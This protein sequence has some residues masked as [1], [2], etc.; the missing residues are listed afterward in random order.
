[1]RAALSS[2]RRPGLATARI[3]SRALDAF[4][5]DVPTL[6]TTLARLQPLEPGDLVFTGTPAGVAEL[7]AGD[8]FVLAFEDIDRTFPGV[9]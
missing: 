2:S 4:T 9:L 5:F 8:R 3:A 6:L 7:R 1:M